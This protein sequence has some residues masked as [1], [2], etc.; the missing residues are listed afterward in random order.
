MDGSPAK[1]VLLPTG[2]GEPR[3]LT[4]DKAE[5]SGVAWLPDSKSIVYTAAEPGHGPRTYVQDIQGGAPRALTPE[6]TAGSRVTPDG[7]Y[8]LARDVKRQEW[9]VPI[10]GG[11]SQRI[12]VNLTVFDRVI[13]FSPDG[14]SLLVATRG[15]PLKIAHVDLAT[16]HREPWKEIAPADPAGVQSIVGIKF[17]AD[18]KSYAYSTLRVLSDLYVVDGLK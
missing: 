6:G 8:V 5:H 2:V 12:T 10:A 4:D 18:G 9:L 3:P 17:S 16:G 15:I 1:L 11:D 14:K 13:G 7:K